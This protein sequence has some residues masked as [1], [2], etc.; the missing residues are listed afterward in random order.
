MS[1]ILNRLGKLEREQ[2]EASIRKARSV[3]DMTDRE[4]I[5]VAL[6]ESDVAI[7]DEEIDAQLPQSEKSGEM[8]G[9]VGVTLDELIARHRQGA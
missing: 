8:Q 6:N 7:S 5:R 3:E 1:S 4:L 2:L 9:I